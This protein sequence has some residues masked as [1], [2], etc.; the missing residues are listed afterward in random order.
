M[1]NRASAWGVWAALA[2]LTVG[3]VAATVLVLQSP[4]TLLHAAL[5]RITAL[6]VVFGLG[7]LAFAVLGTTIAVVAYR[8]S[9]KRP[10]LVIQGVYAPGIAPNDPLQMTAS[11]DDP[12]GSNDAWSFLMRLENRG[13][14]TAKG[15]YVRL[16][17][18][19]GDL[20]SDGINLE[21]WMAASKRLV[22]PHQL[23]WEGGADAAVHPFLQYYELPMIGPVNLRAKQLEPSIGLLIE[24]VAD[25]VPV[26]F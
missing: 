17:L 24:V 20:W 26:V 3:V 19:G 4:E 16:T 14:V 12:W 25:G 2:V 1:I 15:V 9:L 6:G 23:Y 5:D 13:S 22:N 18:D 10:R 8:N 21:P 11:P 7:A